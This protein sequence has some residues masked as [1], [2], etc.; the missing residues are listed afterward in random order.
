[1]GGKRVETN[2]CPPVFM[3]P[4]PNEDFHELVNSI[5]YS[6]VKIIHAISMNWSAVKD[7]QYRRIILHIKDLFLLLDSVLKGV[8][9]KFFTFEWEMS[10]ICKY[11]LSYVI[12]TMTLVPLC[13]VLTSYASV[14]STSQVT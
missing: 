10:H 1:M 5:K 8:P 14:L 2:E 3:I 12:L 11:Y 13:K 9:L 6:Q 7:M 4:M